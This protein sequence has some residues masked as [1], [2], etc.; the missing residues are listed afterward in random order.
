[1]AMKI[2]KEIFTTSY[3]HHV[4][5]T[6]G[7]LYIVKDIRSWWKIRLGILLFLAA[8]SL[9]RQAH[10]SLWRTAGVKN[11][12]SFF[13]VSLF[14][15]HSIPFPFTPSSSWH[16]KRAKQNVD[17][18]S[19]ASVMKL[20]QQGLGS[21]HKQCRATVGWREPTGRVYLREFADA[22]GQ[23]FAGQKMYRSLFSVCEKLFLILLFWDNFRT[24]CPRVSKET[25]QQDLSSKGFDMSNVPAGQSPRGQAILRASIS[26]KKWIQHRRHQMSK[27][28][29]HSF[30]KIHVKTFTKHSKINSL[31]NFYKH[32]HTGA[33]RHSKCGLK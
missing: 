33:P 30:N 1:M 29:F 9:S 8:L 11:I 20:V 5:I 28:N 32:I 22:L 12:S 13:P 31:L 7:K 18:D 15:P 16:W 27:F 2:D 4:N 24:V 17:P 10:T 14:S 26:K 3:G 6:C 21:S 25:V 23:N 19:P